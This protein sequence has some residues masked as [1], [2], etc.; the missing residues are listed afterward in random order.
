MAFGVALNVTITAPSPCMQ[1]TYASINLHPLI[2][3]PPS[4]D[5]AFMLDTYQDYCLSFSSLLKPLQAL[6]LL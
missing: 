6:C 1:V 2:P 4:S 5:A 3:F